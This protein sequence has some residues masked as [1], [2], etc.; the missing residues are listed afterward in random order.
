[1]INSECENNIQSV[2]IQTRITAPAIFVYIQIKNPLIEHYK[3][4]KNG[5]IQLMT[6]DHIQLS[7]Y[8]RNCAMAISNDDIEISTVNDFMIV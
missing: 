6:I 1:M 2:K 4:S 5:F 8:N 7:F 3:L